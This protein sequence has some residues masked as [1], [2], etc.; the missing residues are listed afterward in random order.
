MRN[1][2]YVF[3]L[4]AALVPLCPPV[5]GQTSQTSQATRSDNT[6]ANAQIRDASWFLNGHVLFEDGTVPTDRVDIESICDGKRHTE[7]HVDKKG[8]FSFRLGA[9]NNSVTMDASERTTRSA[10][11]A[12]TFNVDPSVAVSM[13]QNPMGDCVIRAVLVGYRSDVVLLADRTVADSPNIGTIVLHPAGNSPGGAV[14]AA[15]LAVPKNAQKAFEKGMEA[16]RESKHEEAAKYFQ[17]A[18]HYYPQY[19]EA[20]Y[21]LGT[22][23]AS[24]NLAAASRQ[25]FETAIGADPNFAPPYMKI[26][27]LEEAA[28]NWKAL[29]DITAQLL[30]IAPGGDPMAY[31]YNSAANINLRDLAAAEQ[32]ARAGLKLDAR[33]RIPKFWYILGVLLGN[34]GDFAG[35]IAQFNNY[36]QFAPD[37]PDAATVRKQL[38][39][40][41]K[42]AAATPKP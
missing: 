6:L 33:H 29:A 11:P 40:C 2:P 12:G 1:S 14:S 16:A 30:K 31:L 19:A 5:F 38:E 10:P 32:S 22:A 9:T 21:Q 26:A 17:F 36:L 35:A 41:Q 18:V 20:W 7:A 34:R 3:S 24:M 13:S 39:Q 42:L 8:E 15:S 23:Q 25:S 28:R 4:L 27:Q 37:G